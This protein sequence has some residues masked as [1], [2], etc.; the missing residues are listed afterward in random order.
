MNDRSEDKRRVGEFVTYMG[1][2]KPAAKA[3]HIPQKHMGF[4]LRLGELPNV[5]ARIAER[6]MGVASGYLPCADDYFPRRNKMPL[7]N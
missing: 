3:L 6:L 7:P 4:W 1:G 5:E 2:I